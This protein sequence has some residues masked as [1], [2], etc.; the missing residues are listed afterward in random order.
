[1]LKQAR[2]AAVCATMGILLGG[3]LLGG[4]ALAQQGEQL[5]ERVNSGTVTVSAAASTTPS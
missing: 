5:R 2:N 3:I 1:M 4:A